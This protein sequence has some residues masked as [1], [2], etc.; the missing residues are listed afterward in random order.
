MKIS[1]Q[2]L[3]PADIPNEVAF[4]LV[5]FF[6]GLAFALETIYFDQLLL[7]SDPEENY[8]SQDMMGDDKDPF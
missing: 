8:S 4:Q 6:R 2:Q 1:L 3:L 7:R 5:Q